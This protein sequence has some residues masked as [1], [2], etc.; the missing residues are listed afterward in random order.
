VAESKLKDILNRS[1]ATSEDEEDLGKCA[2]RPVVKYVPAFHVKGRDGVRS[3]DYGHMGLKKFDASG[4][5]F[6]I[7]FHEPSGWRMTVTGRNLW[8]IYN[9]L[10]LHRLE[11]VS[12]ADRDF[13]DNSQPIITKITIEVIEDDDDKT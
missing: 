13:E 7:E 5:N 2:S 3:F 11:W 9:Y 1:T 8:K 4:T 10:V 12:V 6:V